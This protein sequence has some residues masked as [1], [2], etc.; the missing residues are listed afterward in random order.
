MNKGKKRRQLVKACLTP[1]GETNFMEKKEE[2]LKSKAKFLEAL[3]KSSIETTEIEIV[4]RH[5]QDSDAW[6]IERRKR[7]TASKFG[8]VSKMRETTSY[9]IMASNIIYSRDFFSRA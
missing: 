7:S 2:S 5:Q 3:R 4:T 9:R 6:Y 1:T 8:E